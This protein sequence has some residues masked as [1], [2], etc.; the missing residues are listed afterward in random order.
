MAK[1]SQKWHNGTSRARSTETSDGLAAI[2]AQLNNLRREIK[3]VNEK[4]YAAQVRERVQVNDL[5]PTIE[6]GEVVEEFRARNDARMINEIFRYPSDHDHDKKI[7][8]DYAYNLKFPYMIVLEDMDDYRDE[9]MGDVIFGEPFLNEV[10]IN[11]K[12]SRWDLLLLTVRITR[13]R[14]SAHKNAIS[15]KKLRQ[16]QI[17]H[18]ND[19]S[20]NK[21]PRKKVC[22]TE[23]FEAVKYSLG[24]NE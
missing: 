1:F 18:K 8:V 19:D 5:M 9:E 16:G 15:K 22:K 17:K 12:K 23:K 4:L 6:E 10:G 11:A 13:L 21:Q 7:H 24:P 20:D 14:M 2:Q 3:K